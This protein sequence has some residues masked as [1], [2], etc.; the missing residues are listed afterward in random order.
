MIDL[1]Q[2][3]KVYET[4][5]LYTHAVREVSLK[6]EAGEFVA[7]TGASGSGKSSLLHMLGLL[8]SPTTGR[9]LLDGTDVTGKS[10]SQRALLRAQKIGFIFQSFNLLGDLTVIQNVAL[11]IDFTGQRLAREERLDRAHAMLTRV[12]LEGRA[13]H[14]PDQLSGGQQQRVAVARSLIND[15]ALLLADE[16]TGNLDSETGREVMRLLKDINEGHATI[17]M[18]THDAN[19]ARW[20]KR[21]VFMRDGTVV[22]EDSA[23]RG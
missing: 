12:G 8:D 9:Y 5:D 17:V 21:Q 23:F 4:R 15:P 11:P 1:T 7:I 14:R 6:V 19:H 3:S 2:V 10:P 22:D 20:A 18:V 13:N 16:P